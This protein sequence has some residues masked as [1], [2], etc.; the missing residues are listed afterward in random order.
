VILPLQVLLKGHLL[1]ADDHSLACPLPT[2]PLVLDLGG[3]LFAYV[4]TASL[5]WG[6]GVLG[7]QGP[8]HPEQGL[9]QG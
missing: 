4:G 5:C 3:V 2:F 8:L 7:Q 9:T 1:P 6:Q